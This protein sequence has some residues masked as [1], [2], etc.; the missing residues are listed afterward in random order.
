M[1]RI[2]VNEAD[3]RLRAGWRILLF[4]VALAG[5]GNLIIFGVQALIGGRP[6]PGLGRDFLMVGTLAVV[7]TLILPFGRRWLDKRD[8]RS[9]GLIWNGQ[10]LKDLGFGWILSGV[11]AAL[12]FGTLSLG[13]WLTVDQID[14]DPALF[15]APLT[16][17]FLVHLLVGWWEELFFRG[18]L[19]DNLTE[20]LGR[21]I[22]ILVSCV[23]YGVVHMI[24]P[25]A[26]LL[27]GSII[28]LFGWMRLYGLLST[29]QLWLS[30][31]MHMGWNF[32]Q[33]PVFGFAAS[34]HDT[35]T[36]IEHTTSGAGWITGGDFGPEASII[37]LPVIAL[38]LWAMK[39]WAERTR[40]AYTS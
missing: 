32:F 18:Y 36:L 14:L 5:I 20:G 27:S 17:Y 2:F 31:G 7:T 30:M 11:M 37:T 22:A 6:A 28:I 12:V 24:N 38:A 33:G 29:R 15:L 21:S 10:A 8:V 16:G 25:N 13:G 34:G 4:F 35:F 26:S 9:L 40:D 3:G 19:F 23:L 1:K 39:W